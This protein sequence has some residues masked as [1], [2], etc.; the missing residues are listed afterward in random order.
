MAF[1]FPS[2]PSIGDEYTIGTVTYTW[3]GVAWQRQSTGGGGSSTV[4]TTLLITSST[5]STSTDTGALRVVGGVGIGL[6]LNVGGDVKILSTTQAYN[7]TTGAL[8]VD[9]GV[10]IQKDLWVG[11]VLHMQGGYYLSPT[12]IVNSIKSGTDITVVNLGDNTV[13]LDDIS[14][15]DTVSGRGNSTTSIIQI[16][17]TTQADNSSTG[18]LQVSGG[19]GIQKNLW[20]GGT[21]NAVG[22]ITG[23]LSDRRLKTNIQT[24]EN[25]V[26]KVAKITG[27]T[28]SPNDLAKE[29]GFDTSERMVGVF[30][31]EVEAVLP[32]A[33]KPVAFDNLENYKTVQYDK[34]IPLLI[35]AIKEQQIEI[36]KLKSKSCGNCGC[37]LN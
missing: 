6:N 26:E 5:Q 12:T 35:E 24:I 11:G 33:V 32:E 13:R 1:G 2:N 4:T 28:F 31:D 16:L 30:A 36:E 9:G 14:T 27:M 29:Y 10:G 23:G 37:N 18:A 34:L 21:I 22:T 19:V 15:F 8:V 25:A 17:N 3:N 7:S 20:V